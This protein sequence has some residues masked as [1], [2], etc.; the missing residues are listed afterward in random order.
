MPTPMTFPSPVPG[1][2]PRV[3][4]LLS[5]LS[6][7]QKLGQLVMG[8]R[9]S[10]TPQDVRT[11]HLGTLLSGAGS[12]PGENAAADWVAMH[13]AYWAAS[14]DDGP[15]RVPIPLLYAVDAVHGH[16]GVRGATVFP[17]HVGLGAAHD[18]DLVER[19]AAVCA[20]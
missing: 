5:S 18:P 7:P 1:T 20:R 9:A 4:R 13:D 8:E 19:I 2:S 17:H 14:M 15:G 12:V 3:E 6:L 16:A 10:V 11:H